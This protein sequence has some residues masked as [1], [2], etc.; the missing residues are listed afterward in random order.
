M[1][2]FFLSVTVGTSAV[3]GDPFPVGVNSGTEP[4]AAALSDSA[5]VVVFE[6]GDKVVFSIPGVVPESPLALPGPDSESS[7][8]VAALRESGFVA[9]WMARSG[10]RVRPLARIFNRDGVPSTGI[11]E[12]GG[13]GHAVDVTVNGGPAG[14][15]L[16]TWAE[17]SLPSLKDVFVRAHDASGQ[18]ITPVLKAS[19][20]GVVR[21][22]HPQVAAAPDGSFTVTWGTNDIEI[23]TC[24]SRRHTGVAGSWDDVQLVAADAA[25]PD[26]A[27]AADGSCLIAW[28][29]T[30]GRKEVRSR[31]Q[32]G[33]AIVLGGSEAGPVGMAMHP[34]GAAV[35]A[36]H[37][38][39]V[40]VPGRLR[41]RFLD[42]TGQPAGEIVTVADDVAGVGAPAGVAVTVGG[43]VVFAWKDQ[44]T[45]LILGRWWEEPIVPSAAANWGSLKSLWR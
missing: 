25:S 38:G 32:G 41:A 42:G 39:G 37:E 10:D 45:G 29:A 17:L 21:N 9:V 16:V 22:I 8:D 11:L 23:S 18:P 20:P 44:D 35:V 43:R 1:A 31:W 36:W 15:F 19:E 33:T 13:Q 6:S 30:L 40:G 24:L 34:T 3:A 2:I 4:A 7:P 28:A 14:G 27:A 26:I 5:V 12:V